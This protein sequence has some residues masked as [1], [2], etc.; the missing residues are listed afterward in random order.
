[1]RIVFCLPG[2]A[3]HPTGGFKILYEYANRLA[4]HHRVTVI[5]PDLFLTGSPPRQWPVRLAGW[6]VRRLNLS[7]RPGAWFAFDPRVDV[8]TVPGLQARFV[9]DAEVVVATAWTTAEWVRQ[10][11]PSKGSKVYWVQDYEHLMTAPPAQR[12]RM[13]RTYR[14]PFRLVVISPALR[15]FLDQQ[16]ISSQWI[17]NAIDDNVFAQDIAITSIER[18]LI[19]FPY[20]SEPYKGTEDVLGAL[21]RLIAPLQ[22]A[23]RVW[24]FGSPPRPKQLP[25]WVNYH[26]RPS[27][28]ELC[29]LYN[30]TRIF[31]VGSHYE[32][33]GLPG[34]EAMACG[35]T[36]VSTD[37]GGSLAYAQHN[38][39]ALLC[40][41]KRPDL[42]ARHVQRLLENDALRVALATNG[43]AV[44]RRYTWEHSL[45][46]AEA[47]FSRLRET[48]RG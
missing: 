41:P 1:M 5:H 19:G 7:Y 37:N 48:A 18:Q 14:G 43:V 38:S 15:D 25:R 21:A 20:R 35:A 22:L 40:P 26:Q 8:R 42:L 4:R 36:L 12:E 33:W 24:C 2:Y 31:V 10:Y 45:S 9:P 29:Q 39:N 3:K 17:P 28:G 44:A 34:M 32:G 16:G 11:P 13:Q 6:A 23:G 46:Q 30:Q 47:L 27:D